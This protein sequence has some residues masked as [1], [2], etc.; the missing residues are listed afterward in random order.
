MSQFHNFQILRRKALYLKGLE[1][2]LELDA[3]EVIY[4]TW[5]TERCFYIHQG[6]G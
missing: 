5:D 1:I 3:V 2:T 6:V 4:E